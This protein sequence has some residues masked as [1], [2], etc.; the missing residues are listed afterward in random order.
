MTGKGRKRGS[1]GEDR[2]I[3]HDLHMSHICFVGVGGGAWGT[4]PGQ[5]RDVLQGWAIY[6]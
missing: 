2:E 5:R 4:I 1:G 6:N 3:G